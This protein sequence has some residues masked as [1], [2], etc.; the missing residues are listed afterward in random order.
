MNIEAYISSG[1]L[2]Q[3]VLN[4]TSEEE[5]KEIE[6]LLL[7]YPILK[8]E[9][10]AIQTAFETVAEINSIAPPA[11]LRNKI[12]AQFEDVESDN[13]NEIIAEANNIVP[14]QKTNTFWPKLSIAAS[15]LLMISIGVNY[16][17]YLHL[18]DAKQELQALNNEK[19]VLANNLNIQKANYQKSSTELA[20]IKTPG[21]T[22]IE[23]AHL[24]DADV[25]AKATIY[26]NSTSNQVVLSSVNLP[27]P[28][29]EQQYQ[30]WAIVDGKPV[31][32]GVFDYK[33]D[34]VIKMKNIKNPQAFAI[35][36]ETKGGNATPLGKMYVMGKV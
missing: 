30:L 27:Q 25:T 5:N 28:T 1:I 2:E 33:N 8:D 11:A 10:V 35:T 20:I 24:P 13:N 19:Q 9:L 7:Q 15:I 32:A 4:L 14:L 23:L 16:K 3:Y 29:Q 6:L 12:L 34:M 22:I 31:D 21:N 36:L 26:W 17:L 18:D